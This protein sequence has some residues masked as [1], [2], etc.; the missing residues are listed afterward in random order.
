MEPE[1]IFDGQRLQR[2][3]RPEGRGNSFR[4]R[5]RAMGLTVRLVPNGLMM[6]PPGG[7]RERF[8][9]LEA[10]VARLEEIEVRQPSPNDG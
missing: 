2:P 10:L 8:D 6:G 7:P 1:I 5:A 9:T 3:P 4:A